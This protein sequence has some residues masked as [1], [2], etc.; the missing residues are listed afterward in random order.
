MVTKKYRTHFTLLFAL[1]VLTFASGQVPQESTDSPLEF[2]LRSG[3]ILRLLVVD[4][5]GDKIQADSIYLELLS[6][7]PARQEVELDL[8]RVTGISQNRKRWAPLRQFMLADQPQYFSAGWPEER[9]QP[10]RLRVLRV[11]ERAF[12]GELEILTPVMDTSALRLDIFQPSQDKHWPVRRTET[13]A[14][15]E[16]TVTS[17][18]YSPTDEG[19]TLPSVRPQLP[20]YPDWALK[21]KIEG[22]VELNVVFKADGTYGSFEIVSPLGFGLDEEAIEAIAN[23][24]T[25]E[26]GYRGTTPVDVKALVSVSF[27]LP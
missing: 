27:H 17:P 3:E 2:V 11:G 23:K 15:Q 26:P 13:I 14:L 24:W 21:S 9:P 5:S 25:F 18:V 6:T 7:W 12:R 4:R 10:Y 22:E 8:Y 1:V 19:V 20:S 16:H